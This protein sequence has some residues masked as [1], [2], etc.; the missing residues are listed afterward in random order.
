VDPVTHAVVGA[1]TAR[2]ILS[3]SV[4][5]RAWLPG[6]AG[7]LL[8][9][10]DALIRSSADPLL[11]AEFH[12]HFTHALVLIPAGGALAALPWIVARRA[13]RHWKSYLGA[14]TAGYATHGL[15]DA[16]TTYGTL[17]LWPFTDAR[18]AWNLISIVDPLFTSIVI[19]GVVAAAWRRTARP[20]A[21]ALAIAVSYLAVG[22]LQQSRALEAQAGVAAMRG[23]VRDRGAVFPAF[24]TNL[25]W[26]SLY[27]RGA[28][29]YM[30]RIRV[31]WFAPVQWSE[32][33]E[34]PLATGVDLPASPGD[35]A[36]IR[37]D[38]VRFRWF[39]SGWVA[40][41]PEEPDLIG[42]ARY[43]S[44]TDRFEPVWGIRLQPGRPVPIEWVDRSRQRRIDP[45]ELWDELRG[46]D[47]RYRTVDPVR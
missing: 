17:L 21:V 19:A 1:A 11:Y 37:R 8:P 31:P 16:S 24:A 2:V 13:R 27:Q 42:D 9:D 22:A 10:A 43:S 39:A 12:R 15:L 44:A 28:T 26:R 46:T 40:R 45:G 41:V 23:H 38:F 34:M 35:E 29:L 47:P 30:D 18:I 14:A 33:Y 32:G 7:A 4:A 25:V 20:A 6:A 3:R 5:Q 36:R